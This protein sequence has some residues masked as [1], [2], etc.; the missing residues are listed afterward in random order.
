MVPEAK[1]GT[2]IVAGWVFI[3]RQWIDLTRLRVV[4]CVR[5][6]INPLLQLTSHP[7]AEIAAFLQNGPTRTLSRSSRSLESAAFVLNSNSIWTLHRSS[8]ACSGRGIEGVRAVVP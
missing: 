6:R 2:M 8:N 4:S 5:Y 3:G 7:G 1:E